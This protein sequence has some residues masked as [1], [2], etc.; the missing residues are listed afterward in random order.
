MCNF[1]AHARTGLCIAEDTLGLAG[2]RFGFSPDSHA[3][4]LHVG[5]DLLELQP[6]RKLQARLPEAVNTER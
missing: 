2:Y 4:I 3:Q 1:W 6:G 5:A